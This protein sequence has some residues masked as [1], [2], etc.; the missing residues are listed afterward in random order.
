MNADSDTKQ[1]PG[2]ASA[3]RF[4]T[5]L[6][7]F[8]RGD[9]AL[10]L[11]EIAKRTGLVKSTALRLSASLIDHSY[12]VKDVAGDY[13]LGPE[14][15]RLNLIYNESMHV[16]HYVMPILQ[17]LVDIS[18]ETASIY[19]RHGSYRLC[20]YRVNSPHQLGVHKQ[21]GEIRAMDQASSAIVLRTFADT[22]ADHRTPALPIYTTGASD[23]YAASL[24]VPVF[25]SGG[26]LLG[27]LVLAG[28]CNRF[29]AARAE[30]LASEMLSAA[31]ELSRQLGGEQAFLQSVK[32][33]GA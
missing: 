22:G 33:A 20:Q 10:S 17:S 7:C 27:A 32:N 26:S 29:D 6:S 31:Q 8:Q 13:R 23:P 2:R 1:A 19:I 12:L 9:D 24:A 28:P 15:A 25:Q 11:A 30:S 16:E 4:L 3:D 21:P 18:G 14:I 5:I